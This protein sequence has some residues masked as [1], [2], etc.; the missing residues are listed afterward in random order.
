[1]NNSYS[2]FIQVSLSLSFINKFKKDY[3]QSA[4]LKACIMIR[5]IIGCHHKCMDSSEMQVHNLI[6]HIS[7]AAKFDCDRCVCIVTYGKK[8][9]NT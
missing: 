2:E 6:K 5:N 3:D 1:M 9:T 8:F 7:N 4:H